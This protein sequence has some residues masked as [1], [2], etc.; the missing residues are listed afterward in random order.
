M[1]QIKEFLDEFKKRLFER[2]EEKSAW[3]RRELKEL[4]TAVA[5]DIILE[6]NKRADPD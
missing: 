3:G 6:Q 1:M 2:L 5:L 4:V